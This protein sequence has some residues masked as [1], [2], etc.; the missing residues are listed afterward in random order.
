MFGRRLPLIAGTAALTAFFAVVHAWQLAPT[1]YSVVDTWRFPWT[2]V[3][4]S[5]LLLSS[6]ALGLPE[7][8]KTRLGA[9]S[10]AAAAVVSAL[11]GVSLFQL[12]LG[13]PL[14]PRV[15]LGGVALCFVPWAVV[16]WNAEHDRVRRTTLR[17]CYVG[18]AQECSELLADLAGGLVPVEIVATHIRDSATPAPVGTLEGIDPSRVDLVVLDM[19]SLADP[20]IVS[21]VSDAHRKGVRVRTV[22]L[23]SEEFLGKVPVGDL[24]RMSLLFDIGEVHRIRYVRW[25]RIIDVAF[26]VSGVVALALIVPFVFLGNLFGNRG[27]LLYRQQRVG[28]EGSTFEILKLRSMTASPGAD[29][30]WTT[31]DD[32]R[33][34]R[35]G[36]LLRRSHLDELP[37]AWNVLRGDLSVVGPRPEQP[38]YVA[39]LNEKIPF[40]DTRHLVRPGLTGW[41]QVNYP[42]GANEID[43][44]EKLQYDLY[45]LRHQ[46][47]R[48]DVQTLI[49]TMR[50]VVGRTGR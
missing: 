14:L 38:H 43:A 22:S 28:R 16:C 23:F 46:S 32:P 24:E 33:I 7:L 17:A 34:T 41:A 8:P 13:T 45:Y 39:E 21:Q 12:V 27:Q 36:S 40:Y 44:R 30:S 35:F 25:K 37:Q 20:S 48:L 42:Y 9:V 49:R 29:T 2:L 4:L 50:T 15:V 19:A 1:S 5:L 26:G 18:S 11:V 47:P 6:Y 31:E 10:S 3:Y